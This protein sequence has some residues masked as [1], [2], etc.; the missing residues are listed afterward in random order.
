LN[1]SRT[2]KSGPRYLRHVPEMERVLP[3]TRHDH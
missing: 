3:R 2:Y 1:E